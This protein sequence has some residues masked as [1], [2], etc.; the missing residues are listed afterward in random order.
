MACRSPHDT[1]PRQPP[2]LPGCR[3]QIDAFRSPPAV[4]HC[5]LAGPAPICN[6]G[7]AAAAR[8]W[9]PEVHDDGASGAAGLGRSSLPAQTTPDVGATASSERRRVGKGPSRGGKLLDLDQVGVAC[10]EP[11]H[12]I[13]VGRE[14][15]QHRGGDAGVA[16]LLDPFADT[17]RRAVQSAI[18]QPTTSAFGEQSQ[19]QLD[20]KCRERAASPRLRRTLS[21]M[22][23]Q[24]RSR[25]RRPNRPRDVEIPAN[26]SL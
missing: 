21:A 18:R 11:V 3:S 14:R 19:T 20:F 13:A 10:L 6:C 5:A 16:P 24:L 23:R 17:R 9:D 25:S 26:S 1:R 7:L 8:R 4:R 12:L 2:S 15:H 22:W